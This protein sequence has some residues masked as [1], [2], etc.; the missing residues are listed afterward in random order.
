MTDLK[1]FMGLLTLIS[2]A[3]EELGLRNFSQKDKQV[4]QAFWDHKNADNSINITYAQFCEHIGSN[5]VSRSQY[6][7]SIQKLLDAKLI[8]KVGSV[9]SHTFKFVI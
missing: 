1:F 2:S 4:L 7:K 3:E 8:C 9:R 6:F 5:S